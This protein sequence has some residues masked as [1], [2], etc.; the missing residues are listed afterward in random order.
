MNSMS[1]AVIVKVTVPVTGQHSSVEI[2][3]WV[4][5][6]VDPAVAV[7]T[8][9]EKLRGSR[10]EDMGERMPAERLKALGLTLG[11]GQAQQLSSGQ[12]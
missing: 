12:P 10:A 5:A 11:S 7:R 9:E 4:I 2:Q 1:K 3:R 8:A 6:T